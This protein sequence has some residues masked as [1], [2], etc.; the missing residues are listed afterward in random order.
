MPLLGWAKLRLGRTLNS[1]ATTGEGI[2]NLMCAVQAATALVAL[3]SASI[4]LSFL[5]PA[6]A[7]LIAALALKAGRDGWQGHDT[8][9]TPM[10]ALIPAR[11][12]SCTDDCCT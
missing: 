1:G 6:A 10:P 11:P 12:G 3:A 8:C 4:G 5:D 2:Q 7:L 9:C